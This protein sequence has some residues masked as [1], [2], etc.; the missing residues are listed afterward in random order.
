VGRLVDH[1]GEE[2]DEVEDE[3]LQRVDRHP[4]A[5]LGR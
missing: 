4:P 3:G 5:F 1:G 2:E